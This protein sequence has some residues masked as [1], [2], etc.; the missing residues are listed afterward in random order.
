MNN[1]HWKTVFGHWERMQ[2]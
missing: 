1:N 2:Q